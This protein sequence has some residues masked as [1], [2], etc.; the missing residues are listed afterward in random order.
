MQRNICRVLEE[1]KVVT[2]AVNG[3]TG[4]KMC[5]GVGRLETVH[6]PGPCEFRRS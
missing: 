2:V 6:Y 1:L 4:T 3:K 5:M